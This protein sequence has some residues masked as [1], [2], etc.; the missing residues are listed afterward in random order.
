MA[1][2]F[3]RGMKAWLK[4]SQSMVK[5]HG[6]PWSKKAWPEHGQPWLTEVPFHKPMVDHVQRKLG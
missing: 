3:N 1:P 4:L 5:K 2:Q 6:Q